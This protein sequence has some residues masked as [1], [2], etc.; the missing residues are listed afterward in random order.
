MKKALLLFYILFLLTNAFS[1]TS[2]VLYNEVEGIYVAVLPGMTL[3]ESTFFSILYTGKIEAVIISP[4]G[5]LGNIDIDIK[6]NTLGAVRNVYSYTL[7]QFADYI[8]LSTSTT[9]LAGTAKTE[10]LFDPKTSTF[11]IC[12]YILPNGLSAYDDIISTL[13][14]SGITFQRIRSSNEINLK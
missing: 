11:A 10:M 14:T 12:D 2:R 9:S 4:N 8:K 7:S 13:F 3:E 6:G 5:L 1:Q